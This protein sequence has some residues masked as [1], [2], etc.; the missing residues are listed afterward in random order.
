MI[1]VLRWTLTRT[2]DSVRN[3]NYVPPLESTGDGYHSSD[4]EYLEY[5]VTKNNDEVEEI[6]IRNFARQDEWHD[7]DAS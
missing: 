6:P 1:V 7:I 2:I 3:K 5:T 4:D